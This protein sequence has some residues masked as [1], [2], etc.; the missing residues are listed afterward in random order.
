MGGSNW[1]DNDEQV[2]ITLAGKDIEPNKLEGVRVEAGSGYFKTSWS[3][4]EVDP[5]MGKVTVKKNT[6]GIGYG[7]LYWQ[8]FEQLDKI[9]TSETPLKLKKKLF[10]EKK[11]DEGLALEPI[12]LNIQLMPGDRVIVRIELIVDRSMDYI[13]LK[14]M[15]ASGL[16]PENVLSKYKYHDGLAYYQSIKD[17]S[18][19]FFIAH[20]PKGT[21]V[22]EYPLRVTHSGDF[23]NG[24]TTIQS[25]YAPE[26][27]SH[28]NGIR[29]KVK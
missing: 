16:E 22:F 23:S 8:Y 7:A 3:G 4:V 12:D 28:S 14:D 11:T 1:I 21:F 17:A 27:S 29:L 20:L 15:R 24:I 19:N 26:F 9:T 25:M 10:L 6:K 18:V 5:E 13:H 2:Q